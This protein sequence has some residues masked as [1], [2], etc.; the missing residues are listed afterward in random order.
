MTGTAARPPNV[1]EMNKSINLT[2]L[3]RKIVEVIQQ[4]GKG[5]EKNV[6]WSSIA[7][8]E[9]VSLPYLLSRVEWLRQNGVI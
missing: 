2:R 3:E 6:D 8:K 9:R 1:M 7:E 5:D 4:E